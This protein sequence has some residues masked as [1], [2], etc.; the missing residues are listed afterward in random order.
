LA[1]SITKRLVTP[2]QAA[3]DGVEEQIGPQGHD[4]A[5]PGA[6]ADSQQAIGLLVRQSR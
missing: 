1:P 6:A 5:R 2:D 4:M 3:V